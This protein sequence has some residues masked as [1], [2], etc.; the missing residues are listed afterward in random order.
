MSQ[1]QAERALLA[2]SFCW[3]LSGLNGLEGRILIPQSM[4]S[5]ANFF[6]N[7]WETGFPSCL[8]LP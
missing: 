2:L 5:N 3:A 7:T 1:L 6:R 8:D 4:D